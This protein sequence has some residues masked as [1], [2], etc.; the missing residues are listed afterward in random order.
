MKKKR[1]QQQN[2]NKAKKNNAKRNASKVGAAEVPDVVHDVSNQNETIKEQKS[3]INKSNNLQLSDSLLLK[4]Q[5]MLVS[6]QS[7]FRNKYSNILEK[8][9]FNF[10][11]KQF[12]LDKY[13]ICKYTN[14]KLITSSH[15]NNNNTHNINLNSF[16][17][18]IN[19]ETIGLKFKID[20]LKFYIK[21]IEIESI[22]NNIIKNLLNCN[23]SIDFLA[24]EIHELRFV[25]LIGTKH[26]LLFKWLDQLNNINQIKCK[27]IQLQ[28][29]RE[30]E[31][32]CC[33]NKPTTIYKKPRPSY[34]IE[35]DCHIFGGCVDDDAQDEFFIS[36][37]AVYQSWPYV[38][39]PGFRLIPLLPYNERINS[40]ARSDNHINYLLNNHNLQNN[41]NINNS[42]LNCNNNNN[43]S[44]FDELLPTSYSLDNFEINLFHIVNKTNNNSSNNN[45]KLRR[46]RKKKRIQQKKKTT[47]NSNNELVYSSSLGSIDSSYLDS[48][49]TD[50]DDFDN[51]NNE[52]DDETCSIMSSYSSAS[53]DDSESFKAYKK[54]HEIGLNNSNLNYKNSVDDYYYKMVKCCSQLSLTELK[55]NNNNNNNNNLTDS[56]SFENNNNYNLYR[57]KY[58]NYMKARLTNSCNNK[59]HYLDSIDRGGSTYNNNNNFKRFFS[60]RNLDLWHSEISDQLMYC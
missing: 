16:L 15:N 10:N 55:E 9:D 48:S 45:K 17:I 4:P 23:Q 44:S 49:I 21:L 26:F 51:N 31:E 59:E 33:L 5:W 27:P 18:N 30:E 13:K 2:K 57:K 39:E 20:Y 28:P 1:K 53:S 32:E 37:G 43:N 3:F 41:L 50:Y 42:Q 36:S 7:D 29:K 25:N 11:F 46:S 47:Y 14:N 58:S 22:E 40:L 6:N 56:F 52:D 24:K 60:Q 8:H 54:R 12:Q 38:Y 35:R 34:L 19:Y